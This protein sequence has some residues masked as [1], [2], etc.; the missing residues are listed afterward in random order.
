MKAA[1]LL[2]IFFLILSVIQIQIA[3]ALLEKYINLRLS[4]W[5]NVPKQPKPPEKDKGLIGNGSGPILEIDKIYQKEYC[6]KW[7]L[8]SHDK[9]EYE[10]HLV[11]FYTPTDWYQYSQ[12]YGDIHNN[13]RTHMTNITFNYNDHIYI[14]QC[15][16][17]GISPKIRASMWVFI[18][19]KVN[20]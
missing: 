9:E 5:V 17:R 11:I 18:V 15:D 16:A 13:F 6:A 7:S 14:E 12:I 20:D 2:I 4:K 19:P 1:A 10:V 3:D 8:F